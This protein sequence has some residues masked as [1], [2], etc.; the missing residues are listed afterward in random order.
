MSRFLRIMATHGR[1]LAPIS[2]LEGGLLSP[3]CAG[4]GDK[5]NMLRSRR[6]SSAPIKETL[7]HMLPQELRTVATQM[8]PIQEAPEHST[9]SC[10][11]WS[12][13]RRLFSLRWYRP[14]ELSCILDEFFTPH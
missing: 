11:C 13:L 4:Y 3:T 9:G 14:R 2:G 8:D 5:A 7:D 12:G 10:K 1:P 6:P